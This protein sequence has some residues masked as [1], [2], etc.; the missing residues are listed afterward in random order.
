[1]N[2][3]SIAWHGSWYVGLICWFMIWW[4][5][6]VELWLL[7]RNRAS[8]RFVNVVL[9]NLRW[10]V[11]SSTYRFVGILLALP[12]LTRDW[13]PLYRF[14]IDHLSNLRRSCWLS[15]LTITRLPL[16]RFPKLCYFVRF[17][18]KYLPVELCILA[19]SLLRSFICAGGLISLLAHRLLKW[20][21]LQTVVIRFIISELRFWI[22][23]NG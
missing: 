15:F 4:P 19:D 13:C 7:L 17:V 11:H 10:A 6:Y 23:L 22:A 3:P 9:Q 16:I 12:V 20:L 21:K 14:I 5:R 18:C 1:M 2:L 8:L